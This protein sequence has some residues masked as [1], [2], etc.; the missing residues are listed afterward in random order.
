FDSDF[1][2]EALHGVFKLCT[3]GAIERLRVHGHR[4]SFE[5]DSETSL[6]LQ[7]ILSNIS[8]KEATFHNVT[9][10]TETLQKL[11]N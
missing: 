4:S 7:K 10:A 2:T 5:L 11:L 6:V 1:A 3:Y 8:V 9:D